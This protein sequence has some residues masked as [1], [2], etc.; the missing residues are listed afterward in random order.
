MKIIAVKYLGEEFKWKSYILGGQRVI[1]V[2]SQETCN[3]QITKFKLDFFLNG[4][5]SVTYLELVEVH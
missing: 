1:Q 2:I 5:I 3:T 4:L